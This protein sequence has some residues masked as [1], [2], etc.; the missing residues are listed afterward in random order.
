MS[1][2]KKERLKTY[3][4]LSLIIL[5]LIQM[6][7][8]WNYY[9]H[10]LPFSFLP[11]VS[12]GGNATDVTVQDEKGKE[13][14]FLPCRIIVSESFV[15]ASHWV[16]NRDS[17]TFNSLWDKAKI[18][19]RYI[20]QMNTQQDKP[21]IIPK[22]KWADIAVKG[23]FVY[24][25]KT[26]INTSLASWFL[27]TSSPK[28][29]AFNGINKMVVSP[30]EDLNGNFTVYILDSEKICKYVIPTDKNQSNSYKEI[31]TKLEQDDELRN[32]SVEREIKP[33]FQ[34][35]NDMPFI[36]KGGKY[37]P[38][39]K[40]EASVPFDVSDYEQVTENVL[41]DEKNSY[42]R[43]I[44]PDN[45]AIIF[46]NSNSIYRIYS[47]GLME[48]KFLTAPEEPSKGNINEAFIKALDFILKRSQMVSGADFYISAVSEDTNSNTYQFTFDYA[49]GGMPVSFYSKLGGLESKPLTNAITIKANSTRVISC[50]WI[51]KKFELREKKEQYLV[52][53]FDL[54][55]EGLP[56]RKK[57]KDFSI[58]D[59][60][61]SYYINS[62]EANQTIE[63]SFILKTKSDTYIIPMKKKEG[64]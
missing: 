12:T 59:A 36:T 31:L 21:E 15:D 64:S 35:R 23:P 8:L 50:Q 62:S 41:R 10:G 63:P 1:R 43:A 42:V 38:L 53:L 11:L 49:V 37:A 26:N 27:N 17:E 5:S 46:K 3:I 32:Y 60:Q 57:I 47:N 39:S 30:R 48:Y 13:A 19:L 9:N 28:D 45:G 55:D 51:L 58:E 44:D 25:F 56:D 16:L 24:E 6:G 52:R 61:F 54:I 7:A 33:P 22:E 40:L 20:L 14:F 4:L 29:I 18:N 34:I 2:R